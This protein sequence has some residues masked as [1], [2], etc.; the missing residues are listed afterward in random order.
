[1]NALK[2]A[3]MLLFLGVFMAAAVN[4]QKVEDAIEAI[5][6]EQYDHAKE[7]LQQ[8]N[9]EESYYYLG[10]VYLK[11]GSLEEAKKAFQQ[12]I[13][14]RDKFPLNYIGLGRVAF[15]EQDNAAG[16]A[17]IEEGIS[18][19]RGRY[20]RDPRAYVEAMKAYK[21]AGMYDKGIEYGNKAIE[22]D[23]EDA[24]VYLALGDLYRQRDGTNLSNAVSNY[25][26]AIR[27]DP[28]NAEAYT[29]DRKSVV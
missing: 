14:E 1:M 29:R 18:R 23:S 26:K 11:E 3:V 8:I 27:Y 15:A 28:D 9:D 19:I 17:Q 10:D 12:G 24:K 21:D 22:V 4:A 20:K 7:I 5:D 25:D 13:Q 6:N 16:E 2:K